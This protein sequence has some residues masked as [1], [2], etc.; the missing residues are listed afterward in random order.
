[1]AAAG[2]FFY[3]I[4]GF[5]AGTKVSP[6]DSSESSSKF[7]FFAAFLLGAVDVFFF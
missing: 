1:L 7:G 6:S 5:E 3:T 4:L 2:Y